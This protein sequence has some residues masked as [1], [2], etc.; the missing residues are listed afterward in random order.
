M[1][2]MKIG[3]DIDNVLAD[4]YNAFLERFNREFGTEII[5]EEVDDFFYLEKYNTVDYHRRVTYVD[6][7]ATD[8]RFLSSISPYQEAIAAIGKWQEIGW[9]IHYITA[10]PAVT[11]KTTQNWL[12]KH[13]FW[14]KLTTLDLFPE[15]KTYARDVEY[16]K[17]LAD[18]LGLDVFIEDASAV[19]KNMKIPVFLLDRPWNKGEL[20][21]NVTR[22]KTWPEIEKGVDHLAKSSL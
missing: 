8:H 10:R 15:G 7:L 11:K 18:K 13:G 4:S 2:K 14:G 16:K 6:S 19:A 17:D 21:E 9:M 22:V 12:K 20:P 1:K 3:I 5:Y